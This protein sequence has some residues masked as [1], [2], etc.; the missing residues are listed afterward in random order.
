MRLWS[1]IFPDASSPVVSARVAAP[2]LT[3]ATLLLTAEGVDVDGVLTQ[4][5]GEVEGDVGVRQL[6]RRAAA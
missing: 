3:G 2:N 1:F 4:W 6:V 5:M